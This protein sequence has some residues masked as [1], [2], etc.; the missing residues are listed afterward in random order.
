MV[1]NRKR[2]L[3]QHACT[4]KRSMES[5]RSSCKSLEMRLKFH[6]RAKDMHIYVVLAKMWSYLSLIN[7][8]M[9]FSKM[10]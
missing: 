6:Y 9:R 4:G 1:G 3:I 7:Y 8:C 5:L 10:V 2:R